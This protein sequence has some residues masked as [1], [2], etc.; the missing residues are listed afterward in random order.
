MKSL[1]LPLIVIFLLAGHYLAEV[2]SQVILEVPGYGVLNGTNENSTY[3]ERSVLRV[4]LCF[5]RRKTHA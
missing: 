4:S 5:L 2:S 3:T 1:L